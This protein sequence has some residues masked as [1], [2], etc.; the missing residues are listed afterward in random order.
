MQMKLIPAGSFT[1]G[2]PTGEICR[3]TDEVQHPVVIS[4][5][6]YMAAFECRQR[7]FYTLMMPENY[8]YESWTCF[9]GPLHDG[10]AYTYRF[11]PPPKGVR[12]SPVCWTY[13]MDTI[14]WNRAVEFCRKLTER[15]RQAGR[16]P[17]G[18]VYRLPTEAEWEYACR[19]GTTGPYS[20]TGDYTNAVVLK[21]HTYAGDGGYYTFGVG[22]TKSNRTPNP[23]GLY[24][25]HGNV[26]E[27]C[28]DWY[29][30]YQ[31]GTRTDPAGPATGEK[32]VVR[33]GSCSPWFIDD[34]TWFKQG[35]HPFLRSAAR[36]SFKPDTDYLIVLG[37]RVVLA[38]EVKEP[39]N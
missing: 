38:P 25:M 9:R 16:L 32:K 1:M 28:L 24:D 22:D 30:P 26:W 6:F 13:P 37:F 18:Y 8:D 7:E 27:W 5:P 12:A 2:S 21:K 17:A 19:A 23:W 14:S 34:Q 39:V 31:T 10:A 29:A 15:E 4:K 3:R 36:Y 20:F 35:V 11:P 33:G